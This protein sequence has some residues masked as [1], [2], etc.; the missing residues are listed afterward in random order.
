LYLTIILA[1]SFVLLDKIKLTLSSKLAAPDR[2]VQVKTESAEWL[3][4]MHEKAIEL[5]REFEQVITNK[6]D[7]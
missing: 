5:S 6:K 3:R 1:Q 7:L 2:S 4:D